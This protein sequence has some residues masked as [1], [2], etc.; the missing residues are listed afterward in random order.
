MNHSLY[1]RKNVSFCNVGD[2]SIFL[3]IWNNSYKYI[4]RQQSA[5]LRSFTSKT[6][7]HPAI[8]YEADNPATAGIAT[9]LQQ[10]LLTE[11][12]TV[13]EPLAPVIRNRPQA[14][15]FDSFWERTFNLL[16]VV[17]LGIS[18]L[19][20]KSY[21]KNRNF[22][23]VINHAREM[24]NA[25]SA[26]ARR[27]S[28]EQVCKDARNFIDIRALLYSYNNECLLDSYA[29]YQAFLRRRTTVD[30]VFGVDLCP[31]RAHCWIEYDGV[32]LN[33][34]QDSVLGLTPIYSV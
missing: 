19:K 21:L 7:Q 14:S 15:I 20:A 30:W 12:K 5:Q 33:D 4:G 10:Q 23:S 24:K 29:L 32:I 28:T 18:Y 2:A 11:N 1:L 8:K 16:S 6:S 13:G 25:I 31:F 9:L 26:S 17:S 22:H 34:N 3:D 27:K